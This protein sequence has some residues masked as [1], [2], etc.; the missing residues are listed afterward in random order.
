MSTDSTQSTMDRYFELMGREADFGTC[1]SSE[2][3]WLIADTVEVISG[4]DAVRDYVVAL[5]AT[6]VDSHTR[7]YLIGDDHVYLEGDCEPISSEPGERTWFCVAYDL[8]DG[9]IT[10]MRCYGLGARE[11]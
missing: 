10:A 3:T 11:V 8:A 2:V 6:F 4:P 5:H 7:R 1:Y 9:A